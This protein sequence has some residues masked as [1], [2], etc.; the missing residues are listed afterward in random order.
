[1][2]SGKRDTFKNAP[3]SSCVYVNEKS[4]QSRAVMSKN[5]ANE[6]G[7]MKDGKYPLFP[8]GNRMRFMPN[9]KLIPFNKRTVLQTYAD[10]QITLKREAIEL[11]ISIKDPNQR[12]EAEGKTIG[13][14]ILDLSRGEAQLPIFRH[15]TKKYSRKYNPHA[16]CVSVHPNMSETAVE[17][18]SKLKEIITVKYGA[19]AGKLIGVA[20]SYAS[21]AGVQNSTFKPDKNGFD[22]LDTSKDWYLAGNAKC[23]IEGMDVV[24]ES[25]EEKLA[26]DN[27]IHSVDESKITFLSNVKMVD[28][29][30]TVATAGGVSFGDTVSLKSYDTTKSAWAGHISSDESTMR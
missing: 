13:E 6:Y 28:E 12:V 17:T 15:F 3:Q 10:L 9:Y 22:F 25:P 1:M 11:D 24:L 7:V 19:E 23:M 8:D 29:E 2:G 26:M 5:M 30:K 27:A 21:K 20:V 16:W 18:L 4:L 14:M